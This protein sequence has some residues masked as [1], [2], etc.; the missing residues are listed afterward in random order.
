MT[1][2]RYSLRSAD[3]KHLLAIAKTKFKTLG[4]RAFYH[5]A[6]IVWDSLPLEIR[7]S[8]TIQ[9]FKNRLKIFLFKEKLFIDL[10]CFMSYFIGIIIFFFFCVMMNSILI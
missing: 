2:C 9:V 3:D 7:L 10:N 4:N 8:P 1:Y 5:A 6:P